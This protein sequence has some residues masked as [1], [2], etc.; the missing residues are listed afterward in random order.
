MRRRSDS[1]SRVYRRPSLMSA[2]IFVVGGATACSFGTVAISAADPAKVAASARNGS[3]I[4]ALN[5]TTPSGGP[6]NCAATICPL[7][8]RAFASS[9][10]SGFTIAG[11]RPCA[12]F[13]CSVSQLPNM[14]AEAYSIQIFTVSVRIAAPRSPTMTRRMRSAPIINLRRSMR[15]A[16]APVNSENKS[17][18]SREAMV[19]PAISTGSRVRIA[20]RSGNAV[21]N[22]PSP[23]LDTMTASH[24]ERKL[25]P[26]ERRIAISYETEMRMKCAPRFSKASESAVEN[27]SMVLTSIAFQPNPRA[28]ADGSCDETSTPMRGA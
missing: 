3:D 27:A 4:D 21:R 13:T 15:S 16:R 26:I 19:T 11:I 5:M 9:K 24:T 1:V 28:I 18:G 14:N 20:A 25:P 8:K 22:I 10:S 17:Q 12:A 6:M 23:A 2:N 7:E